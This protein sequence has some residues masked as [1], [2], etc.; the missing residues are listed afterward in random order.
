MLTLLGL[1]KDG[2]KSGG[3][4]MTEI[5]IALAV[6]A[7]T[8]TGIT[9]VANKSIRVKRTADTTVTIKKILDALETTYRENVAFAEKSC[10]GGWTAAPCN[11]GRLVPA[12]VN[13]T[14]LS[15]WLATGTS[16]NAWIN[17]GCS[18]TLVSG[19]LYNITCP[20]GYGG[21]I[22]F[23]N[24][25]NGHTANTHYLNG[26]NK[27]PFQLQISVTIPGGSTS[28]QEVWSSGYLDA[29]YFERSNQK[30]LTLLR[31][32]KAYHFNRLL[33]EANTNV[34]N[35]STGGLASTDDTLIPWVWQLTASNATNAQARCTGVE[36]SPCGC[37]NHGSNTVWSNSTAHLQIDTEAELTQIINNLGIDISH[38]TDGYGNMITIRLLADRDGNQLTTL[39]SRPK[40]TYSACL[41][42]GNGAGCSIASVFPQ[43]PPYTGVAGVLSGGTFVYSQKV[44]YAN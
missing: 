2:I 21:N 6:L 37:S 43:L 26:Y 38:R 4:A 5:I 31:A 18:I 25:Q 41:P 10:P 39:P 8:L 23:S 32:I 19:S 1:R 27:T 33:Y 3:F 40:V 24:L 29:E 44:V 28:V 9:M 42:G 7:I 14:T 12:I 36:V 34:C 20:S 17:A 13:S 15:A 35:A 16:R 22:T 30:I 11:V